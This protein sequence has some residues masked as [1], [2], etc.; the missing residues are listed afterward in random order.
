MLNSE[1]DYLLQF[2]GERIGA[3][4]IEDRMR[5][6]HFEVLHIEEHLYG[7]LVKVKTLNV[8]MKGMPQRDLEQRVNRV[9][10]RLERWDE[11]MNA[12]IVKVTLEL[13]Y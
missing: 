10:L 7:W 2:S 13:C 4:D 8:D 9:G 3:S 11:K 5:E 6:A 12:V 1:Q